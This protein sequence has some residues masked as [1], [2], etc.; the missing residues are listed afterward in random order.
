MAERRNLPAP[1]PDTIDAIFSIIEKMLNE[2]RRKNRKAEWKTAFLSMPAIFELWIPAACLALA[3]MLG[4]IDRWVVNSK[5]L[6]LI[7]YLLLIPM[8]V[9]GGIGIFLNAFRILNPRYFL[10]LILERTRK[11]THS[12]TSHVNELSKYL[13][14]DLQ[15]VLVELKA[16]RVAF[17]RRTGLF[18]G[19]LEKV[20]LAP[21]IVA[22]IAAISRFSDPSSPWIEGLTYGMPTL[23]FVGL[24]AHYRMMEL[25]RV[26][27]LLELVID[28]KKSEEDES[29][30]DREPL[31]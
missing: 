15:Y 2:P 11:L 23:Y 4:G 20:G 10:S 12:N 21:G 18:V 30:E 28:T 13:W 14:Q 5:W 7:S 26:I 25:D 17:E 3:L 6:R 31:C 8:Y 24:L 9:S 29:K 27:N 19:A 22:L 1:A 16:E